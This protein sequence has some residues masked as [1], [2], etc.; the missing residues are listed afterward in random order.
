LAWAAARLRAGA[1]RHHLIAPL[2]IGLP[3]HGLPL[4]F[5]QVSVVII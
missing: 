3:W 4:V 5:E 1:R 2:I